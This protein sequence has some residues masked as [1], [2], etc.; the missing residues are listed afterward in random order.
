MPLPYNPALDG[1]R[2]VAIGLVMLFHF[3]P[4]GLT[5]GSLGV[6]VFFVLSGWLIT[7]ILLREFERTGTVDYKAFVLRRARRLLPALAALLAAYVLLAPV[8]F[9]RVAGERWFDASLAAFYVTNLRQSFW[10]GDYP[11]S[12]T[13]SL[14]IEEQ[15]Y[16]IW[17]LAL[18]A[19]ARMPR[20]K[21]ARA[22]MLAWA[23]L[24]VVRAIW[25]FAAPSA[26]VYY[27]TPLHATGLMLG[28]A[29]ALHPLELR[30]GRYALGLLL[31]LA[32]ASDSRT[33]FVFTTPLAEAATALIILHS[34]GI[35][36][37]PV[38]RFVGRISYGTYL[39]HIPILWV[40]PVH[41][42]LDVG[43]VT[44]ASLAAGAL[45]F[46]LVERRF[47][48]GGGRPPQAAALAGT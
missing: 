11:L 15:F 14:S 3:A 40:L 23:G 46:F 31:V 38:L 21:A 41:G 27:F 34:P 2:A 48:P 9:P 5:G 28:A 8:L 44:I 4:G 12:H 13:W 24:T 10:P 33:S 42:W 20:A 30:V 22:L 35:L 37:A 18:I 36:A 45:S 7:S 17:P 25:S 43:L 26:A 32:M 47:L 1:L 39:W 16:L 6:D 29:L 19:L